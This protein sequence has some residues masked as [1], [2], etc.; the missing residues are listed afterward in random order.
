MPDLRGM[1]S[2]TRIIGVKGDDISGVFDVKE[3][4]IIFS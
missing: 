4:K 3:G 2:G 1:G